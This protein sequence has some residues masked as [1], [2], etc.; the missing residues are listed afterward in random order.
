[1]HT[2]THA[3]VSSSAFTLS[4]SLLL[5]AHTGCRE[6]SSHGYGLQSAAAAQS[7]AA[8]RGRT[9]EYNAPRAVI[10]IFLTFE[11]YRATLLKWRAQAL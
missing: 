1:M 4:P 8:P 2:H 10:F 5:F 7:V 6:Y 3:S 11:R 9:G